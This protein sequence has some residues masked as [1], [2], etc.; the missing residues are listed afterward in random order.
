MAARGQLR[1]VKA[2]LALS[3]VQHQDTMRN[4][5]AP[6]QRGGSSIPWGQSLPC[7]LPR[8]GGLDSPQAMAVIWGCP[9]CLG[10]GSIRVAG[11]GPCAGASAA[12]ALAV[13]RCCCCLCAYCKLILMCA[14]AIILQ[15]LKSSL[16][17]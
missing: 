3:D 7:L 16:N 15:K 8:A 14:N 13:S 17:L 11:E 4:P 10:T 1:R 12:L 9:L 5:T 2:L 6:S